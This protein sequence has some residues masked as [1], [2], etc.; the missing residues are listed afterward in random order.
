[1]NE[2]VK[3]RMEKRATIG[4]NTVVLTY[5]RIRP[6]KSELAAG[7]EFAH[8]FRERRTPAGCLSPFS[9]CST[10]NVNRSGIRDP[11]PFGAD[12]L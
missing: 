8:Q 10:Q 3:F 4:K 2:N 7:R 6:E 1:M 12:P 5:Y 11:T 9:A